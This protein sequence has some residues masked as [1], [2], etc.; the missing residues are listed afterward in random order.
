MKT[1]RQE[2][3]TILELIVAAA[4]STI[5]LLLAIG[6]ATDV[7]DFWGRSQDKLSAH[8]QARVIM[9]TLATDL[10][11]AL[12]DREG[13]WMAADILMNRENS[14]KWENPEN[15]RQKPQDPRSLKLPQMMPPK[16]GPR[17]FRFGAAGVWLR[18]FAQPVDG[19]SSGDPGHLCAIA[20]QLI[21]RTPVDTNNPLPPSYNLYR[22]VVSS[23][24]TIEEVIEDGGYAIDQFDGSSSARNAGEITTPH[25]TAS[26]IG[27]NVID[28]GIVLHS[29]DPMGHDR[30][31]FP[32][33]TE[34]A[35]SYRQDAGNIPDSA[36]IHL[37]ILTEQ[38]RQL[39][40]AYESGKLISDDP[41]FWWKTALAHSE[42]FSRRIYFRNQA[43]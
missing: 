18:F 31:I 16:P 28:F 39:I 33:P 37:R 27:L 42:T 7:L 36:D 29:R 34:N 15:S 19:A 26:L 20:Y 40:E 5:M 2:G 12:F 10:E 9:E 1:D 43:L 23:T 25:R 35:L 13:T 24:N 17:D 21:R 4:I 8:A 14:G 6:L 3:F 41:D 11:S 22:S 32:T 30:M 38:G